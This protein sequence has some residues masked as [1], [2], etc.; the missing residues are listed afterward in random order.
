MKF[1]YDNDKPGFRKIHTL[2]T[3]SASANFSHG[4][5]DKVFFYSFS[6]LLQLNARQVPLEISLLWHVRHIVG[7]I[8]MLDWYE[9]TDGFLIVMERPSPCT[10]LFD[11]ISEKQQLN[12]ELARS[13]FKQVSFEHF[14]LCLQFLTDV[15]SFQ[16]VETIVACAEAGVLHRDIKDENLVV[17]IKTGRLKLIDFGS[18]AFLKDGDYTDFEG[19]DDFFWFPV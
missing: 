19:K 11:Y 3:G 5:V 17:D 12:E 8:R 1:G 9:R 18:G 6:F 2:F 10:D 4:R 7:V 14:N 15:F 13:F 16:V